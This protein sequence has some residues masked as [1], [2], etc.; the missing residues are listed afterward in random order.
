MYGVAMSE[1]IDLVARVVGDVIVTF[2]HVWPFL[3]IS[4]LAAVFVTVYVGTD[5]FALEIVETLDLGSEDESYGKRINIK[6]ADY[7][8]VYTRGEGSGGASGSST[9]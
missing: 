2:V 9:P 6:E 1:L 7:A 4:V 5:W 8:S 3:L